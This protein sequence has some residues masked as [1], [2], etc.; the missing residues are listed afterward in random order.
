[1]PTIAL[2]K[3]Q[4]TGNDFVLFD[5]RA[6]SA[7]PYPD[8]AR[9]VCDRRFGIGADGLLVLAAAD[10]PQ[11]GIRMRIFNPDGSEA[12]MCGN[13]I[14]CVWLYLARERVDG[15]PL[16]VQTAAGIVRVEADGPRNVRVEMGV[17]RI[18]AGA[19]EV[20]SDGVRVQFVA[21]SMGNPHAV[22]F[23]DRPLEGVALEQLAA[24]IARAS[25]DA[26][27][28]VELVRPAAGRLDMRVH[29]RGVGETWGCGTGA[30]AAAAVAIASGRV[31]SPVD[32]V[33]KGGQVTVTWAGAGEPAYLSGPAQLVF[34]TRIDVKAQAP[35]KTV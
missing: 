24:C 29:E 5:D 18:E 15:R 1:M 25:G 35:P 13:G 17:P 6:R 21:V 28:N 19:R 12:E 32:V 3:C 11:A 30:C 4:A 31:R 8:L 20:E 34:S 9:Q 16:D 27:V 33:S 22:V 26:Q 2:T 14:R 10:S 7:L 23:V